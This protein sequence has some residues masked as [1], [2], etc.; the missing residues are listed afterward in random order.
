ML[1]AAKASI[2]TGTKGLILRRIILPPKNYAF[3]NNVG[4]GPFL[5]LPAASSTPPA[6]AQCDL[7]SP[8]LPS[9]L[10]Y[11]LRQSPLSPDPLLRN[12]P[13]CVSCGRKPPLSTHRQWRGVRHWPCPRRGRGDVAQSADRPW[14]ALRSTSAPVGAAPTSNSPPAPSG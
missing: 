10:P 3:V 1:L 8:A 14:P 6:T 4:R 13:P 5:T 7:P 2:P 12:A 9:G 11:C